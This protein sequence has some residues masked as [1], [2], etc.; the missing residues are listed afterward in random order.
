MT[1]YNDGLIHGWNGG[2]CPVHPE[3]KVEYWVRAG[4]TGTRVAGN[5]FWEN[6]G[7]AHNIIAF[8][9]IEQYVEPKTIWVNEY[10]SHKTMYDTQD[11][12]KSYAGSGAIRVAVE[13]REV[14]K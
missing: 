12:A 6:D 2:D 5:L 13:F 8:R 1:D 7:E 9:V 4:V 10:K 14:K 11:E 3:S